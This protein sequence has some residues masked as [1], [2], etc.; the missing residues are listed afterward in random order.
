[1]KKLFL[2]IT[3]ALFIGH[4]AK[5]DTELLAEWDN[6]RG[7]AILPYKMPLLFASS[8]NTEGRLL[9]MG[10]KLLEEAND[11]ATIQVAIWVE[12]P[13]GKKVEMPS[14]LVKLN[15]GVATDCSFPTPDGSMQMKLLAQ[16]SFLTQLF[17]ASAQVAQQQTPQTTAA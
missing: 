10:V 7:S 6:M 12:Y 2:A 9:K 8:A 11:G 14:R 1:M 15:W 17:A 3:S 16:P 5:P 13:D 4:I